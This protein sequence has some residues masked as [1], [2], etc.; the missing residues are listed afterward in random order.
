MTLAD[1]REQ[2]QLPVGPGAAPALGMIFPAGDVDHY[3]FTVDAGTE[4]TSR[5]A[6]P[7]KS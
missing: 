4:V 3:R 7:M 6:H 2:D 1:A 5:W